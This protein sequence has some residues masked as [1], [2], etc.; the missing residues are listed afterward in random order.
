[1]PCFKNRIFLQ[2]PGEW[3][4]NLFW[5]VLCDAFLFIILNTKSSSFFNK[6][7]KCN[8]SQATIYFSCFYWL[9]CEALWS[10]RFMRNSDFT[11]LHRLR[12]HE[13]DFLWGSLFFTS[14]EKTINKWKNTTILI[15][16]IIRG[17]CFYKRIFTSIGLIM[18]CHLLAYIVCLY[19]FANLLLFTLVIIYLFF[20]VTL[21]YLVCLAR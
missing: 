20:M 6:F 12:F 11:E 1:M 2:H 5:A 19:W 14:W 7:L 4:F 21:Q 8:K 10:M 3:L 16:Y 18:I 15:K 13:S 17:K 9:I